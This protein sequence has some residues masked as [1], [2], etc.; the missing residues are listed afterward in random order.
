MIYIIKTKI[1]STL[2]P[3][4]EDFSHVK[5]LVDAGMNV[6]RLN[7]SHGNYAQFHRIIHN[8]RRASKTVAILLDTMGPEMRT[9]MVEKNAVLKKGQIF[10]LT[11]QKCIG[12][13]RRVYVTYHHLAREVK[14]GDKLLIDNG[15]IELEVTRTT[16]TDII[17]KVIT[18]G[19]LADQ[20][21]INYPGHATKQPSVTKKDR[22]DIAFGLLEGIDIIAVS[23]VRKPGDVLAIKKLLGAHKHV[24]VLAK[25]ENYD[26]VKNFDGILAV[27]DGIMVA[28]GDLGVELP[29]EAVPLIQKHIIKK[30]NIAGKP[31]VTATQ[32]LESMVTNSRPTRAEASD[33][34]NAILDGTDA[35]MTSEETAIG[36]FP[37]HAVKML[38]KIAMETEKS[39]SLKRDIP[40]RSS[41]DAIAKAVDDIVE[42]TDI[43]KILVCTYS[44][45]SAQTVSKFRPRL[46]IIAITPDDNTVRYLNMV[47]GAIPLKLSKEVSS[48]RELLLRGVELA[49]KE[50]LLLKTDKVIMTAAH[51]LNVRGRMNMIEVHKVSDILYGKKWL[52]S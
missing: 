27:A 16:K 25:I 1:I 38:V 45:Y 6:A 42:K 33:V 51:P 15:F 18:G 40:I 12:N 4:T 28:R 22:A 50:G 23:M 36:E 52:E 20:K 9:G 5:R 34:A 19:K 46:P 10:T 44:G 29:T 17:C 21:G 30:C 8:V 7:F 37:V 24:R 32:M 11:T 14:K 49:Y 2:G 35:V 47:W 41:D 43:D 39:L 48:L 26:A 13:S 3:A 31:V